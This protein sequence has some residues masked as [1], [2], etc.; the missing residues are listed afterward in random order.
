MGAS[1][2]NR[3]H[4][5]HL[6]ADMLD[7]RIIKPGQTFDFNKAIGQR[8]TARGFLVGQQIENGQLV[9]AVGGGVCQVVTTLFDSAFYA[10]LKVTDR[11]NH[12]F[13]ISHYPLGMDATVSWGGPEFR[14]VN[15]LKHAIMIK[16]AYTNST[17]VDPA[18]RHS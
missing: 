18:L 10:G 11:R 16:T 15:T 14:F 6:L 17:Y 9:P 2:S 7:G 1:S 5:V 8:T 13:Y 3:I 12:D 4:N